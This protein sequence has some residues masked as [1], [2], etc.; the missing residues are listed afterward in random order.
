VFKK[1]GPDWRSGESSN[2]GNKLGPSKDLERGAFDIL[3]G[4]PDSYWGDVWIMKQ[5]GLSLLLCFVLGS[6]SLGSFGKRENEIIGRGQ[7]RS[8]ARVIPGYGGRQTPYRLIF[9]SITSTLL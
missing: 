5:G 1:P 4:D 8:G 2:S 9:F 3:V 7:H 6:I